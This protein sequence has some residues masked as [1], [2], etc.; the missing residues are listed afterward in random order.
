[1]IIVINKIDLPQSRDNL[2]KV[3]PWFE[4]HGLEIFAISAV[5]GEGIPQLLDEIARKLWGKAEEEYS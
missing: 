1:M 4:E 3:T 5:T 2:P